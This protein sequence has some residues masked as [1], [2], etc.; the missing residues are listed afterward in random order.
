[1]AT[2]ISS[3]QTASLS[4]DG[5]LRTGISPLDNVVTSLYDTF[6]F[7]GLKADKVSD[8]LSETWIAREPEEQELITSHDSSLAQAPAT[9]FI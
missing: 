9:M 3:A 8:N 6:S 4:L 7:M 2:S 1:M 5:L